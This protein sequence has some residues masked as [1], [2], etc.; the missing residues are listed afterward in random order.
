[1]CGTRGLLP[2]TDQQTFQIALP[3][4]LRTQYEQVLATALAPVSTEL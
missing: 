4:K 2:N 3:T 1:M